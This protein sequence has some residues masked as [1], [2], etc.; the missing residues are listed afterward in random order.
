MTKHLSNN[1]PVKSTEKGHIPRHPR[2]DRFVIEV[3]DSIPIY[4]GKY[5]S[6]KE[7]CVILHQNN[8]SQRDTM[9]SEILI[10]RFQDTSYENKLECVQKCEIDYRETD[11]GNFRIFGQYHDKARKA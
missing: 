7:S 5:V 2:D 11:K 3:L 10:L 6:A 4:L 9:N 8:I 1:H